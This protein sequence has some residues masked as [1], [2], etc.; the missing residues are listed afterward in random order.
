MANLK[1]DFSHEAVIHP[2]GENTGF[3]YKD[4]GTSNFKYKEENGNPRVTAIDTSAIDT[5]AIKNSLN[6]LLNF[7]DGEEPL[8]PEF[9][10]SKILALIYTPFDKYTAQKM[11]STLKGIISYYEPRIEITSIPTL[12]DEDKGEY[13]LTINYTIPSLSINDSYKV[14]F[15]Q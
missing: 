7:K 3:V 9:G 4:I 10:I 1:F 5:A 13:E 15:N 12:Y 2:K 14:T 8:E 6:N 11:V